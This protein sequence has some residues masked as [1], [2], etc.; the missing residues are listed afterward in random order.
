[1]DIQEILQ[2]WE[3]QLQI[4]YSPATV[5]AY[6]KDL[7]QFIFATGGKDFADLNRENIAAFARFLE[8]QHFSP[9]TRR[10]KIQALR[11]FIKFSKRQGQIE[12]PPKTLLP[13]GES[14]LPEII[15]KKKLIEIAKKDIFIDTLYSLGIRESE[16]LAIRL[17]DVDFGRGCILIHGKGGRE[18]LAFIIPEYESHLKRWLADNSFGQDDP[19]FPITRSTLIRRVKRYFGP[20]FSPHSIRHSFATHLLEAGAN[21]EAIR[22]LLGHQWISTTKIYTHVSTS[23]MR[24][25]YLRAFPRA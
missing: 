12:E 14:K 19:I 24:E 16:M 11:H 5:Q 22:M 20:E 1:M 4:K 18:R 23:H 9:M 13:R 15:P 7:E 17:K 25:E 2:I 3:K 21:L 6:L 10:R 8:S